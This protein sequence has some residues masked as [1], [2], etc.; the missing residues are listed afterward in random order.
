MGSGSDGPGEVAEVVLDLAEGLALG[1]VDQVL[2]HL[3]QPSLG[4]LAEG[5]QQGLDAGFTVIGG[6]RSGGNGS[7]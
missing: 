5:A 3:T 7:S 1:E 4:P 6:L 2:G